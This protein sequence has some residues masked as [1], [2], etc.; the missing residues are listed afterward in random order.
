MIFDFPKMNNFI[1]SPLNSFLVNL[2]LL[3]YKRLFPDL[4]SSYNFASV[5]YEAH[6]NTKKVYS[7]NHVFKTKNKSVAGINT[8][9]TTC[10]VE[11]TQL[12]TIDPRYVK[13]SHLVGF[14]LTQ[15]CINFL[16]VE[17]STTWLYDCPRHLSIFYKAEHSYDKI[18][19]FYLDRVMYAD[20]ITC[21]TFN[22]ANQ[23]PCENNPKIGITL[24][25]DQYDLLTPQ[26]NKKTCFSYLNQLKYKL[27]LTQTPLLAKM[28]VFILK[29]NSS[30]SGVE[31]DLQN[32]PIIPFN[33]LVKPLFTNL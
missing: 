9:H 6:M 22:Y 14:R 13:N 27:L 17:G 21:K 4:G 33:S 3:K 25:T 5:D 32:A 16:Y 12:L 23:I 30:I 1:N 20:P 29:K 11:G 26:P 10:E 7:V 24:D 18:P 31:F 28:Q 8:L 15:N 2:C 19:F